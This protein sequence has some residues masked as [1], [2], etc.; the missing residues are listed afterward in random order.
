MR[1]IRWLLLLIITLKIFSISTYATDIDEILSQQDKVVEYEE[2]QNTVDELLNNNETLNINYKDIVYELIHGDINY[3]FKDIIKLV[4]QGMFSEVTTNLDLI[5]KMIGIAL[6]AAIFTNFTYAFDNKYISEVGYFVVFL[7]MSAIILQSYQL[8]SSVAINVISDLQV[9]IQ[10][11]APSL[12]AATALS[13]NYTSTLIYNQLMLIIIGIVDSLILQYI[14]PF[15]YIIVVLEI[16]NNITEGKILS[17]MIELI[18]TIVNWGI[19]I[20]M[21]VFGFTLT[22]QSFTAPVLDGIAN[23][24]VKVAVGAIPFLGTTLS[25]VTDAVMGCAVLIKNGVGIAALIIIILICL[26]PVIK[27][28]SVIFLYK[29]TAAIIQPIS[30]KRMVSFLSNIGDICF[31]LLGIVVITAFLFIVSITITLNAT[32]IT[33]YIR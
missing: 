33:A 6:V 25:G 32:N 2:I 16:V 13:G 21:V 29:V 19:K 5:L 14:V 22:I 4:I 3:K 24:S 20:L 26:M 27:I 15:V 11:L 28:V 7:L 1:K 9:F 12:F 17:K 10:A 23:K 18:K 8:I 30:D 31:L